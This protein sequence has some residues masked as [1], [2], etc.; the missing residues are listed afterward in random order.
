MIASVDLQA[1]G[2]NIFSKLATALL[3]PQ[4][5]CGNVLLTDQRITLGAV[6]HFQYISIS[7]I[8]LFSILEI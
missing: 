1:G 5:G 6:M 4:P 3:K 7:F 8:N 2:D